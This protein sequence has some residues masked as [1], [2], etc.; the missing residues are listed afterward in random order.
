M[1]SIAAARLLYS[2]ADSL[3]DLERSLRATPISTRP[4]DPLGRLGASPAV[5]ERA[6]GRGSSSLVEA[7]IGFVS[8]SNRGGEMA[9]EAPM[10][11]L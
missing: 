3:R 6:C 1:V 5:P 4:L 8:A 7:V 9:F 10:T 11:T 2:P